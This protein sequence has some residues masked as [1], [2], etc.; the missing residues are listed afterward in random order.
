MKIKCLRRRV[1]QRISKL[2]LNIIARI[3]KDP[4]SFEHLGKDQTEDMALLAVS[5][6]PMV[7]RIVPQ[8]YQTYQVCKEAI[9]KNPLVLQYIKKPLQRHFPTGKY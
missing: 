8:I 4:F 9:I 5:I 2:M 3:S 1:N 6:D 7:L